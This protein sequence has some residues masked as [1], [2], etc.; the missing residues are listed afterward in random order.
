MQCLCYSI[1][2]KKCVTEYRVTYSNVSSAHSTD[3]NCTA[4]QRSSSFPS[5]NVILVY[6]VGLYTVRLCVFVHVCRDTCLS[7][8]ECL[9]LYMPVSLSASM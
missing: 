6:T 7:L 3:K 5:R 8:Y 9:C 4:S 2:G 1:S